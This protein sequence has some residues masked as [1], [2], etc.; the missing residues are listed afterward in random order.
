MSERRRSTFTAERETRP[1]I[2]KLSPSMKNKIGS[3]LST[4]TFSLLPNNATRLALSELGPSL[5]TIKPDAV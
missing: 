5:P 4:T 2:Q 1:T 3:A